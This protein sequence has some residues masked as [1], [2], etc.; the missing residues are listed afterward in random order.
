MRNLLLHAILP[1][2]LAI[3][4]RAKQEYSAA[5]VDALETALRQMFDGFAAYGHAIQFAWKSAEGE[6]SIAA[7][8]HPTLPR[9]V[10]IHD[11]FAWGSG[12]KPYTAAMVMKLYEEGKLSLDDTVAKWV[13]PIL[14][15]VNGTSMEQLF[16]A[17]AN[18]ITVGNLLKMQSGLN[19]FDVPEW[20]A[21]LLKKGIAPNGPIDMLYGAAQQTP[22]FL[23]D[24]GQCT[25]YTSVNY[26]LLG[27]VALAAGHGKDTVDWDKLDQK[28]IFARLASD[29]VNSSFLTRGP[30]NQTLTVPGNS[31]GT[32]V[33]SQDATVLGWTCGNLIA[34]ASD[35][36]H[37]YSELLLGDS[38]LSRATVKAMQD[39]RTLN[40]GW[41]EGF[42]QY[43]TGLMVEQASWG[44][45]LALGAPGSYMGHGG[46]TY[47]FLS[48]AGVLP[49]LNASF[50]V[51]ANTDSPGTFVKNVMACNMIETAHKILLN[52]TLNLKCG[53]RPVVA[54][55]VE[56]VQPL[57]T[58]IAV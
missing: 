56:D 5:R 21:M 29:F 24:P 20:D 9:D 22:M 35:A 30:L 43:G 28:T 55:V 52:K 16:G 36:A 42:I 54:S 49:D 51:V 44:G 58:F 14:S 32:V 47:G 41:A 40:K 31:S 18:T 15:K 39:F 10:T 2:L 1:A 11:T 17:K 48:E 6:F 19:D 4:V 27:W 53:F 38:I 23:C 34:P 50:A 7:G 45:L 12:T 13:N 37:F 57:E 26:V 8:R 33:W 46:D 25:E 3:H